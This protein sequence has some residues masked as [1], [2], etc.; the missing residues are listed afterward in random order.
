MLPKGEEQSQE[1]GLRMGDLPLV[2]QYSVQ[3]IYIDGL[4]RI[5]PISGGN[6]RYM[7]YVR[8]KSADGSV[9]CVHNLSVVM[10]RESL[11]DAISKAMDRLALAAV[12]AGRRVLAAILH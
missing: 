7:G 8:Q 11:P 9:L 3:D 4:A 12:D 6:D 10:P 2:E 1:W 5:E